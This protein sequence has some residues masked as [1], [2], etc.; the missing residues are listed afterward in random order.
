MVEEYIICKYYVFNCIYFRQKFPL[1]FDC[2]KKLQD[3]FIRYRGSADNR[4]HNNLKGKWS[5]MHGMPLD[6][7]PNGLKEYSPTYLIVL[8]LT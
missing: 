4:E 6:K 8:V 3:G 1:S 7:Y 5:S 2:A